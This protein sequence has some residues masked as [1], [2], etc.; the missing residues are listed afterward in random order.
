MAFRLHRASSILTGKRNER[1]TWR[2]LI[3]R[4]RESA[5]SYSPQVLL[6]FFFSFVVL[7]IFAFSALSFSRI[8]TILNYILF[9]RY[10]SRSFVVLSSSS[11]CRFVAF[12]LVVLYLK[13][14]REPHGALLF[15][16]KE[17]TCGEINRRKFLLADSFGD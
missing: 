2:S 1:A 11:F 13:Q 8:E 5:A 4:E 16:P 7:S 9:H 3:H 6:F 10:E 17:E 14:I 15:A 12:D